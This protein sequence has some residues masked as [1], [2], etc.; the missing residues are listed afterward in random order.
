MKKNGWSTWRKRFRRPP[1]PDLAV[2]LLIVSYAAFFS[3]YTLARHQ[4][5][6]TMGFDLG[7]VDQTLWSTMHGRILQQTNVRLGGGPQIEF[8]GQQQHVPGL[9][10][11]QAKLQRHVH[12]A[13]LP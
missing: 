9:D 1:A 12:V 6:L 13:P 2:V 3:A 5:F 8:L 10:L 11:V 7:N 4:A